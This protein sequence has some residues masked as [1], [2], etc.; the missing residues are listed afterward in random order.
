M[1]GLPKIT[2]GGCIAEIWLIGLGY[3]LE[4]V[5]L[6]VKQAAINTLVR[7]STRMKRIQVSRPKLL[8]TVLLISSLEIIFLMLWTILDP[9]NRT[10]EYELTDVQDEVSGDTIVEVQYYCSS[11]SKSW[12][13][14]NTGWNAVLLLVA[15]VYAIQIRKAFDEYKEARTLAFLIYFQFMLVLFRLATYFLDGSMSGFILGQTRSLIYSI[16]VIGAC[17]IYF[18]PK[19]HA[20]TRIRERNSNPSSTMLTPTTPIREYPV[21]IQRAFKLISNISSI[22]LPE[23][24]PMYID[25]EE[26]PSV[27]AHGGEDNLR[28]F[29]TS[30]SVS[31]DRRQMGMLTSIKEE[32]NES[33]RDKDMDELRALLTAKN[34]RIVM[35]ESKLRKQRQGR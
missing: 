18:A 28:Q 25:D 31:E 17:C 7:A 22:I 3:T 19:I 32:A 27:R 8:G 23:D 5:P 4:L 9:P 35:L 16:D 34:E 12:A 30:N 15:T 13:L 2:D 11:E 21:P 20:A 10:P 29:S 24:D 6:I 26:D 1:A 14:L 33:L